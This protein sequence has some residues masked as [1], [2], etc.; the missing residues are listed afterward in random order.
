MTQEI[1][2]EQLEKE[3]YSKPFSLSYSGLS[4]MMYSP[5][6]YYRHYV[7]QQ[8]ED[9]LDSY[10]VDGKVIHCL[11]LDNGSFDDQF[12][13]MP[14]D[15]PTGNTRLVVDMLFARSK[16]GTI[17]DNT[18]HIIDILKEINLH[19][20]LKTDEQ[21]V[22]KIVSDETVL[23]FEFLK[24]KGEKTILDK[25]TLDRCNQA[26]DILRSNANVY[27]LLGLD[28]NEFD[29]IVVHN[30]IKLN[31]ET[32]YVCGLHGVID[33]IKIDHDNKK[34][35]INDLKTSGKTLS[36]FTETVEYYS[37]WAQAAIYW[38]LV[39]ENYKNLIDQKYTVEFNFVVI[40]KYNQV[41][42]FPVTALTMM[43]WCARL[44]EQLIHAEWY[45]KNKS[46]TLPYL[47][48]IGGVT[49]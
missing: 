30:E 24:L 10:L 36:E 19:Q 46:F 25:E 8:K 13:L 45:Y 37:Y 33:N 28:V 22:A 31:C 2:V 9:K 27:F 12:I 48:A 15:L 44:E 1:N 17:S 5:Q 20:S 49:L 41:Y 35:I 42:A 23:Y 39:H 26:V 6:L 34:I 43:S 38:K 40:D 21:R 14:A 32:R 3:F 7:L 16:E 11:L 4:K 47:F 29:N 18:Q